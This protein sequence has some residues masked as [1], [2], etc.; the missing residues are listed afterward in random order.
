MHKNALFWHTKQSLDNLWKEFLK[1]NCQEGKIYKLLSK[2][3]SYYI[4]IACKATFVAEL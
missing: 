3:F 4:G 2:H 1:R